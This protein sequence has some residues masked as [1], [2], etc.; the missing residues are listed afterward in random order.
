MDKKGIQNSIVKMLNE[1]FGTENVQ[2]SIYDNQLKIILSESSQAL[3]FVV[4]IEDE[5][6]IEF[7]DDE[8]DI[9]FFSSIDN[10]VDLISQK[11]DLA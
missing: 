3:N 8:I 5:F 9:H 4:S 2:Q 10:I 7:E 6:N 11:L 1:L